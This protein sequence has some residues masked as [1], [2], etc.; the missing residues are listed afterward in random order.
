MDALLSS[1]FSCFNWLRRKSSQFIH[2]F[3]IVL[4]FVNFMVISSVNLPQRN[5]F[6]GLLVSGV[7]V[8]R[9]ALHFPVEVASLLF[10]TIRWENLSESVSHL[11]FAIKCSRHV[12]IWGES[13]NIFLKSGNR[14]LGVVF[15]VVWWESL[16]FLVN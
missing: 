3:G 16:P 8:V 15:S 10:V 9:E 13:A 1:G 7:S 12:A 11:H 2:L 6:Y 14:G 5:V 4:D